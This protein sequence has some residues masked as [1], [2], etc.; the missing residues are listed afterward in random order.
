[1]VAP[2]VDRKGEVVAS[3]SI[4]GP[5]FRLSEAQKAASIQ[6]VRK[7]ARDISALL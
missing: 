3:L 1:L 7:A 4:G 5:V 6:A 2:V